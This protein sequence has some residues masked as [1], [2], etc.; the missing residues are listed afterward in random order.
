MRPFQRTRVACPECGCNC[1][2]DWQLKNHQETH[3]RAKESC[4]FWERTW[5]QAQIERDKIEGA[6]DALLEEVDKA[7][8]A[9]RI[10]GNLGYDGK[11]KVKEPT[12]KKAAPKKPVTRLQSLARDGSESRPPQPAG[13]PYWDSKHGRW[14]DNKKYARPPAPLTRLTPPKKGK[15]KAARKPLLSGKDHLAEVQA[16]RGKEDPGGD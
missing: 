12:K 13:K 2:N 15:T 7:Q 1:F 16:E 3:K 14:T 11:P 10:A 5:L 9:C 8:E 6:R 4:S